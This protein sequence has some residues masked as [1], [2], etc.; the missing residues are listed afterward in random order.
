MQTSEPPGNPGVILL[1]PLAVPTPEARTVIATGLG[2]SG[3]SMVAA[4]LARAGILD[5]GKAYEV[6]LEDREL[7][8][9]LTAQDRPA[10]IEAI[11]RRNET[12]GV[13]AFKIPNLHGYLTPADLGLFRNP[14]LIVLMRDAAAVAHRHATAER[15]ELPHAFLDTA[16]TMAAFLVFLI[17]ASCPTLVVSYEKAILHPEAAV[18]ALMDFAQLPLTDDLLNQLAAVIRP[19]DRGYARTAA[20]SFAGNIDGL[21]D[22]HLVGWCREEGDP[23]PVS[24]DLLVDGVPVHTVRADGFRNDLRDAGIGDGHHGF[25]IDTAELN[26]PA[27]AILS[28][29]VSGRTF[30]LSGS[31]QPVWRYTR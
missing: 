23:R 30:Q 19:E 3:T 1:R 28:V 27:G 18:R 14:Q 15:L 21:F 26:L 17:T 31:G 4:L 10:L 8:H 7:L 16:Q 13:W 12:A 5:R 6:T 25:D 20:R 2:R 11:R 9:V 24:L 29:R 22:G